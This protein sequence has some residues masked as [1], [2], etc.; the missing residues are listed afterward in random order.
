MADAKKSKI[1]NN[2]GN[3]EIG[4]GYAGETGTYANNRERPFAIFDTP[5][6]GVRA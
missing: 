3:I 5:Q 1:Y 2:P 4:Q 6:M